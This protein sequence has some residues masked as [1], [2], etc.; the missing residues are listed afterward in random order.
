MTTTTTPYVSVVTPVYNTGD[1]L[2]E[3]IESVL[4][5]TYRNFEHV[6]VNNCSTDDS[7]AIARRYASRDP[8]IR[9]VDNETFLTQPQNYNHALRQIDPR[10]RYCKM[11]QAD[12][13]IF[14][15][16]IEEMVRVAEL[17][18]Q[19]AMVGAYQL[20]GVRVKCQGIVCTHWNEPYSII[21]GRDACR[22]FLLD[23]R[24]LFGTGTSLLYRSDLIRQRPSFYREDSPF[25]DSEVCFEL[26]GAHR[27]GFV[28]QVLTFTRVGN[29]NSVSSDTA[30]LGP[31]LLH[32]YLITKLYGHLH[33]DEAE[34]ANALAW[35]RH[36]YY[37]LL[38]GQTFRR[39]DSRFW[40]YHRFG[41]RAAGE[42]LDRRRLL[43][44]QARH[45]LE[46]AGNP[47]STAG[48]ARAWLRAK[49]GSGHG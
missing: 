28:H 29:S 12:D 2:A 49:L 10:S 36:D 21:E 19:I 9:I 31:D 41:L 40:E 44:M 39:H 20:S 8:R 4:A 7:L 43:R 3:C 6:I 25:E 26:M 46:L 23:R 13:W 17:D 15:S 42:D 33:L 14:P 35:A 38:V 5:Q 45:L 1:H 18:P 30:D 37:R 16:C 48:S 47:L 11:V 24:Y 32:A 34:L 27:F 22:A